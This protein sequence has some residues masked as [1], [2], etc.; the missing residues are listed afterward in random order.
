MADFYRQRFA[1][2]AD[3]TFLIVG[4]FTVESIT[5][6][7]ERYVASLAGT[8]PGSSAVRQVG[9]TFP[10]AVV[11]ET[12]EKGKEPRS[13][14][15]IAF[16]ADP[17]GDEIERLRLRAAS[18]V[19]EIRLRDLLREDLGATYGVNVGHSS[20]FPQRDYG[21]TSVTYGSSPENARRL[22][23]LV[24]K[25][26]GRLQGEGP[27]ADD[28]GKVKEMARRELETA[29][30]QNGFWQGWLRSAHQRGLDPARILQ[31]AADIDALTTEQ[32]RDALRRYFALDRHTEVRLLPER[33]AAAPG[34]GQ[35]P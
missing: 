29:M 34:G 12:L 4:A 21:Y 25:E 15:V 17:G 23:E 11:R 20:P 19:L 2:A 28:L 7:V 9:L 10:S 8:A 3:F 1:N 30:R 24:L 5:P 32:L 35:K 27:S 18:D 33:G 14:T 31:R 13:Q 16:F 26:I 22:G 6:L